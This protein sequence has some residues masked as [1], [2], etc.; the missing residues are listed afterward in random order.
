MTLPR[1]GLPN[2]GDG[3]GLREE[4]FPHLMSTPPE[5][6][7]VDW[8]E[9]IT[10][11][12]LDNAGYGMRV[13]EHVAAHRPV[14]LHGVSLSIGSTAPLDMAYLGKLRA[15]AERFRPL[16]I[17]DH[18]CWT[19][20]QG[21]NSHDLLP[22]PLTEAALAH[23]ADRVHQVQDFL[24]RPLIVE[25]PSTY[26]EFR[27]SQMPEAEFLARLC[28]ATGCG[29]LLD[30]NNVHVSSFNH[31]QD[32]IAYLE[33]IPAAHVVQVHLAGPSD[34][35]THLIDTHDAPVPDAV[36]PLYAWV[37]ERC[38][39]VATMVEW[40]AGIPEFDVVAAELAKARRVREGLSLA[41]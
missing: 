13:F 33:G 1:L 11:N 28:E 18:L 32:P 12:L 20:V 19:G 15:L 8:F 7:G 40:D 9:A 26:L 35:G 37:W 3:L 27:A 31:A 4:H 39:P 21:V 22:M 17:S 5:S 23:V 38:G 30:V 16:W 25:N 41:A 24:G 6:W 34:H 36:W 14:V 2:P 10:E 29:L